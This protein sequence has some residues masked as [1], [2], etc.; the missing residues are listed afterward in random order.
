MNLGI[1]FDRHL[2]W[3]SHINTIAAKA[4]TAFLRRNTAF[5]QT[6]VKIH[7][8]NTFVHP[9]IEYSTTAWSTYCT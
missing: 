8:Y 4:N 6:E 1:T 7:C 5:C 2:S 3:K 9:I